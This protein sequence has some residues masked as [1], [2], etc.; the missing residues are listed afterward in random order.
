MTR[1][2][3]GADGQEASF[4]AGELFE[5]FSPDTWTMWFKLVPACALVSESADALPEP[6]GRVFQIQNPGYRLSATWCALS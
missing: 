6:P 4:S 5:I 1:F 3:E 2:E